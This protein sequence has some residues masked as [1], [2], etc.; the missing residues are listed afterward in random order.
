MNWIQLHRL[1]TAVL[2]V[3]FLS[4]AAAQEGTTWAQE[5]TAC[6]EGVLAAG[7]LWANPYYIVDSGIPGPTLL[8]A[9]GI[10]G[11]EPA[12]FRAAEQIRHWPLKRGKLIVVPRVNTPGLREK[13][14]WLPGVEKP[15]RN[16]NRNFPGRGEPNRAR[17]EPVRALWA[18]VQEQNPD[19]VVDLH[20]GYDFRIT[21]Q[22]TDGSS[23]IFFDT[24]EMRALASKIHGEINATISDPKRQ[25]VMLHKS[26]PVNGGLVRAAVERLGARGFCFETTYGKQPL[27]DRTRQQRLMVHCLM[28][29]LDMAA[30]SANVMISPTRSSPIRVALFDSAG[31]AERSVRNLERIIDSSEA[32]EL[33]HVGAADVCAGVLDQFH[34]VVFPGGSGSKQAAALG[35][36][37]RDAVRTFVRSGG[38]FVGI[39]AGAYLATAEYDWGLALVN[40]KTFTGKRLIPGEGEKSMWVRGRGTVKVELTAEGEKTF[41]GL[42]GLVEL[43]YANGPILSPAHCEKLAPYTTLAVYRSEISKY[44]AQQ[45][46]MIDTP[47]IVFAGFGEGRVFLIGPHPESTDGLEPLVEQCLARA[48]GRR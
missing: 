11:N 5:K 9:A 30:G 47:A 3:S 34:V 17:T 35:R 38:G 31:I 29:E 22:K 14:R 27:S 4:A 28:G 42:P 33:R 2:F 16:A 18:F 25:F 20:E 13:T 32:L 40:A 43:Y 10:H 24:P 39:C 48:A 19:W 26:G 8:I 15:D 1:A 44:D 23:I 36:K 41:T 7:T 45:G 37:G 46:T 21:N 6:A 12:G